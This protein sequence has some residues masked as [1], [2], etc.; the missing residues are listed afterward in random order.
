MIMTFRQFVIK[1][2]TRNKRL[3]AAYFLSSTVAV[4]V[5]FTFAMFAFHPAFSSGDINEDALFGMAVAGVII[6]VFSFFFV[7]YSMGAFL[8]SRKKEFGLLMTQGMSMRQV[9]FMVFLENI[10]LGIFA[11]V[12]G[13]LLGT[14]FAKLI[15]LIAENVLIIEETLYFYFPTYAILLTFG[16]FIVLFLVISI[17]VPFI[18]RSKK[19]IE[20]IKSDKAPK[21]EP[22]PSIILTILS[23]LLL[24]SSYSIAVYVFVIIVI[25]VILWYWCYYFVS[26]LYNHCDFRHLLFLNSIICF[27][28]S[29]FKEKKN[30]ILE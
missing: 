18:L 6:Y 19:I 11:T 1:N 3:Y 21:Q 12:A 4:M 9:R 20:L 8:Q 13:V 5:F 17:F 2:V 22:K 16:S 7:L 15:L 26:T 14:L 24:I 30:Y 25:R 29:L 23:L 28:N 10:I 27:F